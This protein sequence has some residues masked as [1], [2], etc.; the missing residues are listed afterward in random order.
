MGECENAT[1][2]KTYDAAR[3]F[4]ID[5]EE[6]N[7]AD[8]IKAGQLRNLEEQIQRYS[9]EGPIKVT[10]Y[11]DTDYSDMLMIVEKERL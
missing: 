8:V 7:D 10:I 5:L 1:R 9:K 11:S 6:H 2:D 3:H 4:G